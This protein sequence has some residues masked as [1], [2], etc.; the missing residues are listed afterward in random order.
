[1][2]AACDAIVGFWAHQHPSHLIW[3]KWS[4]ARTTGFPAFSPDDHNRRRTK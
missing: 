1:M 3:L 2:G 4:G